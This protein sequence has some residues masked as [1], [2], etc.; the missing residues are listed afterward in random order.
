MMYFVS[1]KDDADVEPGETDASKIEDCSSINL[2][3]IGNIR[4]DWFLD[5][6]GDDTDVQYLGN[7]HV[8]YNELPKLVKQWRKKDFASQYFTMSMLEN[9][10]SKMA[11][12]GTNVKPE[13]TIKWPL[14]LNIPG[15]GFG[16]DMLQV[17]DSVN[18]VLNWC[19]YL[20]SSLLFHSATQI[21]HCLLTTTMICF[22]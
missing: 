15:E 4:P 2:Q 17:S 3:V 10:P 6:R 19:K 22:C 12:N 18:S 13:D 7:Q 8:F 5:A 14:I 1:W 20:T 9:N 11:D 21:T 16:D